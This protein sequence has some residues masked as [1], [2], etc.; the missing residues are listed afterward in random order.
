MNTLNNFIYLSRL[1]KFYKQ[2]ST[3]SCSLTDGSNCYFTENKYIQ[4]I[5]SSKIDSAINNDW[6][7][8]Y[9]KIEDFDYEEIL[10]QLTNKT[11][12]YIDLY[13]N[14]NDEI[15]H[16]DSEKLNI[17]MTFDDETTK[18]EMYLH[19]LTAVFYNELLIANFEGKLRLSNEYQE[20][21]K[22]SKIPNFPSKLYGVIESD[23]VI[24][25]FQGKYFLFVSVYIRAHTEENKSDNINFY[26]SLGNK[27]VYAY[28]Y[29][30]NSRKDRNW[31]KVMSHTNI[32]ADKLI[33]SGPYDIDNIEFTFDY[34]TNSEI[35]DIINMN[36]EK[37]SFKL[38][39]DD[40]I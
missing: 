17:I 15:Q 25:S 26:G 18:P 22:A 1:F 30:D 20:K 6:I 27:I 40:E 10:F 23:Y 38:I 7:K 4:N 31:L 21:P 14:E 32:L 13:S 24:I 8:I 34:E 19:Q 37:K 35:S 2:S 33:I 11:S 36:I 3:K 28:S 29:T 9:S 5:P 16:P 12:N 39:N